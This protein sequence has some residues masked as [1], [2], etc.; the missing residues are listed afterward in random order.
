[1]IG[2]GQEK[3]TGEAWATQAMLI[4]LDIHSTFLLVQGGHHKQKRESNFQSK[5]QK[6]QPDS[7]PLSEEMSPEEDKQSHAQA[8]SPGQQGAIPHLCC[9]PAAWPLQLTCSL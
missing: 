1:M 4:H 2:G 6:C 3:V 7:K 8:L 5:M 9:S